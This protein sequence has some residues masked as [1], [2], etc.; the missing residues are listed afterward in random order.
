[1]PYTVL[2]KNIPPYH[3]HI[4]KPL[5]TTTPSHERAASQLAAALSNQHPE[6]LPFWGFGVWVSIAGCWCW[7]S[8][9]FRVVG[10]PGSCRGPRPHVKV[11]NPETQGF[12]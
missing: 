12:F 9:A 5:N 7:W 1:M 4:H 8:S 10:T 2:L 3:I 11:L 6:F